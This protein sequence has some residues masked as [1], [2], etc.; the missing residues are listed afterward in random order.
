M[1][2]DSGAPSPGRD[3]VEPWAH[4]RRVVAQSGTSF[5]WGMKVLPAERRRAMYAI[6]AFCRE[7]DDVADEPGETAQKKQGLAAWREE[8]A[9]LYAGEP[10]WPTTRA[11][12]Q[13][14]Q[15]FELPREEFLAVIDG[16]EID[17]APAVRMQTLDDLLRYCRKV[18]GAVGMLSIHA[19]GVPRDPGY[20]IAET[21]GNA[22]QLT[23]IL[24][25]VKED[26]AIERLYVP[27]EVV[28]RHGVAES[29]LSAVFDHPGF[30]AA[31]AELAELARDHYARTDRLLA[32]L[33]WRQMR[34]IVLMMAVY[35]ETLRRLEE[36]GW[37]RID[38]PVRLTRARKLWVALR[39]GLL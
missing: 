16:V 39:H 18:A 24:R 15:R 8:I 9:R 28:R 13:P 30:A 17:A 29:S 37:T 11:L 23:N 25:D 19:F 32:R 36:R 1:A 12:L 22:V 27:L 31:C 20:Q 14:V 6:Y 33:G 3:A 4:V 34:P 2:A 26:A 5:L 35:R 7:V 38:S 10:R 21:L